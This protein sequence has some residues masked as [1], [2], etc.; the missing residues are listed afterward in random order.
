MNLQEA[1]DAVGRPVVYY[2]PHGG[3]TET[4]I[5]TSV[6]ERWVL[7]RYRGDSHSKATDPNHLNLIGEPLASRLLG[8]PICAKCLTN[9]PKRSGGILCADCN[10]SIAKNSLGGA[11]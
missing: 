5:I 7:V 4:G 2:A 8:R 1:A 3:A 9:P 11:R 6:N 10:T